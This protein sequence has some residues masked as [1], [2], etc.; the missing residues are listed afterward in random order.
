MP[1][2]E[3]YIALAEGDEH[4]AEEERVNNNAGTLSNL[5][6]KTMS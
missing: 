4:G 3:G 6:T 2:G 5:Q 1:D